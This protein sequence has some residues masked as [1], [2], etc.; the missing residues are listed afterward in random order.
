MN[1]WSRFSRPWSAAAERRQP[2]VIHLAAPLLFGLISLGLG[3]DDNWDLRN[4]HLYGPF[5][6]L[7][8]K[9]D[10]DFT[11]GGFQVYFNPTLDLAYDWMIRHWPARLAGFAWGCVHGLNF[12]LLLEICRRVLPDLPPRQRLAVPF[13]LSVAGILTPNF[14]SEIGTTMGD[15]AT[16]LLVLSA[17]LVILR[18]FPRLPAAGVAAGCCWIGLA[19]LLAGLGMGL[20]LTNSV[21]AAAL[22]IALLMAPAPWRRRLLHA[23]SY[24]AAVVCGAAITGGYWHLTMWRVFGNPLFPQFAALFPSAWA[25]NYGIVD[26]SFLPRTIWDYLFWPLI[27]TV[28]PKRTGQASFHQAI[29]AVSYLAFCAAA[30]A[31]LIRRWRGAVEQRIAPAQRYLLAFVLAGYLLWMLL[32]SI[33]RYLVPIELLLPLVVVVLLRSMAPWP[34]A[35]AIAKPLLIAATLVF[36]LGGVR[37]WGHQRWA[38]PPYRVDLPELAQ[39]EQTTVLLAT[40]DPPPSWMITRFPPQL[41]FVGLDPNFRSAGHRHKVR[42]LI[43]RRG[44]AVMALYQYGADAAARDAVD[45]QVKATLASYG[46][47]IDF[48]GCQSYDAYVGQKREPY[49]W[50]KVANA[51]NAA[52]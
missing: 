51:D 48:A 7:N 12:N 47:T 39:L 40:M 41:A 13:W 46:M 28:S 15:N 30:A 38:D 2:L 26:K 5:A 17:L 25:P 31:V 34:I 49:Q 43:A 24:G 32:F 1:L 8:G 21:Y 37:F 9:L 19:G 10:I 11:P 20:K 33:A 42:D 44:G 45:A 52:D 16:A 4:Y 23:A 27:F 18:Q 6:L 35:R 3:V 50:C 14:V 29:W 36:L 22:G